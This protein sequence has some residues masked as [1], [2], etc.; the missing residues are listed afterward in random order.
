MS[1]KN[2]FKKHRTL[3]VKSKNV[4]FVS[5]HVLFLNPL[6][7]KR[8]FLNGY[9]YVRLNGKIFNGKL[10]NVING[11]EHSSMENFC[12]VFITKV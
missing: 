4:N 3:T 9:K 8:F 5:D 6:F 10:I 11:K 7:S 2:G 1:F 12:S